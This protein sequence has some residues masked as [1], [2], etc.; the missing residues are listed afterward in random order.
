MQKYIKKLDLKLSPLGFG[1]MRLPMEGNKFCNEAY[2]MIDYAMEAGV[3]YYDTAFIYQK[4]LS[5][6]FVRDSLVLR[7]PREKF[8]IA[9]KLPV[10]ECKNKNDMERIFNIQLERLGVEYI[11]FYLLHSLNKSSWLNAYNQG[12]LDFLERLRQQGKIHKVGFSLHD[13]KNALM[14][15]EKSY[16]WDFVQLQINY[17]DW[18]MQQ[19]DECYEYLV[20]KEIPCMVMGPV[21]GGRLSKL[22]Q[23]AESLLRAV[24]PNASAS[25]WAI[26][27]T[28]SLPNVA[29]TLS[30][31]GTLEQVQ[32]NIAFFSPFVPL[33]DNEHMALK[34]VVS[35]ISSYNAIPCTSCRYCIDDCPKEIDIPTLFQK[36]N[37]AKLFDNMAQFKSDYFGP[38][39]ENKRGI[40]CVSC[41]K[42]TKIC[43][44][45][46]DIPAQLEFVHAETISYAL[47]MNMCELKHTLNT[48]A[49]S[50]LIFFCTG[51]F[52]KNVQ[53]YLLL[54]GVNINYFCD[55]AEHLWG[56]E[57]KGVKVLNP[58]EL[59]MFAGKT[60]IFLF[61]ASNVDHVVE[62]IKAQ[63]VNMGLFNKKCVCLN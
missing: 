37:D 31:M 36:Y 32:N 10:W 2:T 61:I 63:L 57:V 3:N 14:T 4:G 38:F 29:V 48:K 34:E 9:D 56:T 23:S 55:N 25:S 27:F 54:Q 41:G 40:D 20:E 35:I 5:E 59:L 45:D 44:Q 12:V 30:G 8:H 17:Y 39:F 26:R 1:I 21:G 51:M 18:K 19:V 13:D 16:D 47:G 42:C 11:D 46:I 28:A 33:S 60:K 52:S 6:N 22:P 7:H 15:V 43:P 62:K 50:M 53:T 58:D 49:E 24:S